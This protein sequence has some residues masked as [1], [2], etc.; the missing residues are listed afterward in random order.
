MNYHQG[1]PVESRG[2]IVPEPVQKGSLNS[3]R[4]KRFDGSVVGHWV[5]SF[6]DINKHCSDL[7]VWQAWS[8][9]C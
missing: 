7:G 1:L 6:L 5:K 3:S 9:R 8:A 4:V 2:E